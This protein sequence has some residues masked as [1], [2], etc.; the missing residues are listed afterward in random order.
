AG[1]SQHIKFFEIL[2]G[3]DINLCEKNQ[4]RD[5]VDCLGFG[6]CQLTCYNFGGKTNFAGCLFSKFFCKQREIPHIAIQFDRFEIMAKD[7]ESSLFERDFK[8]AALFL[9]ASI[10][11]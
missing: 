8:T 1:R 4:F 6:V 5:L 10:G 7:C 3:T 9:L 2:S 11:L